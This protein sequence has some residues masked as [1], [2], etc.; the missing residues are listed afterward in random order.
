MVLP[1]GV[2]PAS[3]RLED[4]C[5]ISLGHGSNRNWSAR[6]DL[7][8]RSLGSRPSM[9]LLHHALIRPDGVK[10]SGR[11][12]CDAENPGIGFAVRCEIGGLEGSCT[13]NPPADNGALSSLSY[14]SKENLVARLY[15]PAA[16]AK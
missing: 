16:C 11:E 13:L 14:E 2:A 12:K 10:R 3:V 15:I 5:L 9:L 7:H 4:E 8:L 1:A 6:Q